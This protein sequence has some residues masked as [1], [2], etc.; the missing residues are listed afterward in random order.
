MYRYKN[1]LRILSMKPSKKPNPNPLFAI[2]A[3]DY[4]N[5]VLSLRKL[6]S[7]R[8]YS[9]H[10]DKLVLYFGHMKVG[11][12]TK[13]DIQK[14]I[15]RVSQTSGVLTMNHHLQAFKGIMEYTDEDWEMPTRLKKPKARKPKQEFYMF[16]EVRKLLYHG[17]GQLKVLVMLL[18]ETGLRLGEALAL[19]PTDVVD[20][21]ISVTKNI[22]EGFA[23][24]TPKTDS[25]IRK[26]CISK[27]LD[28][29]LRSL[30]TPGKYIFRGPR[31]RPLW[32]QQLTYRLKDLCKNSGVVYKGFHS[33]RRGNITELI[34]NLLIPERIV[35]MRVGHLSTS[36][37]LGVYCKAVEG[38]DKPWIEKIEE[39]LYGPKQ[40]NIDSQISSSVDA[41][42][43]GVS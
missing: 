42:R 39:S 29:E 3:D 18:A 33:F 10:I 8:T 25:S 40:H 9:R 17:S 41:S 37:T 36:V 27:T 24:D 23:Q 19:L 20:L 15:V 32:P 38:Q 12:I 35:G 16:E 4:K 22:Y 31:D 11:D 2:A 14:Y 28:K 26:I 5:E 6:P 1:P 34:L 7:Y 30:M 21:T 43:S 13:Q